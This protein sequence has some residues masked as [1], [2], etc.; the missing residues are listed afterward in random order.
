MPKIFGFRPQVATEKLIGKF[1]D[2]VTLRHNNQ[3]LLGTV[4]VDVQENQWAV[5]FAYNY[6]RN[7]G[8]LGPENLIEA[9]YST[10]PKGN[11]SVCMFRSDTGVEKILSTMPFPDCNSFI[12][13]V[14]EQ[15]RRL[16]SGN[17]CH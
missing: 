7:S 3:R 4:Y 5:A 8:L 13:Y 6:A 15:E 14:I 1:E 16:V 2:E 17:T 11:S 12:A 9:R 10:L